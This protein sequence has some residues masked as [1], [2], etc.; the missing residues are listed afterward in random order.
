MQLTLSTPGLNERLC[1]KS[2][3]QPEGIL[4]SAS[5]VPFHGVFD[6]KRSNSGVKD[7]KG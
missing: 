6:R 3:I 2:G 7:H 4:I 5:A 1:T